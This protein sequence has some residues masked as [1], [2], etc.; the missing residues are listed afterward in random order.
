MLDWRFWS[1]DGGVRASA[2]KKRESQEAKK[3]FFH[4]PLVPFFDLLRLLYHIFVLMPRWNVPQKFAVFLKKKTATVWGNTLFFFGVD[5]Q[6]W[7]M[8]E[9][10]VFCQKKWSESGRFLRLAKCTNLENVVLPIRIGEN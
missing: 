5:K 4:R 1:A 9:V 3:Q 8:G 10:I 7:D 6:V 2:Q